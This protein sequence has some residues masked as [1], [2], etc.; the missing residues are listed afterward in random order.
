M[1]IAKNTSIIYEKDEENH[2]IR[3]AKDCAAFASCTESSID[4]NFKM[5]IAADYEDALTL[6]KNDVANSLKNRK[7][8]PKDFRIQGAWDFIENGLVWARMGR[9]FG[10]GGVKVID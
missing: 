4:G 3:Y 5:A 9:N 6:L 8:N 7:L 2:T 10:L 1:V